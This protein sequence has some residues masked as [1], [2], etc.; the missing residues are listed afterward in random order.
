MSAPQRLNVLLSRARNGL[1]II[2]NA[3]TFQKSR[4]A[5]SVWKPFIQQLSDNGHLFDGFPTKCEQHPNI[6]AILANPKDFDIHCPSG[7]CSRDW[8]VWT[9]LN[10]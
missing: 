10:K 3:D 6:T 4:K 1:I 9:V 5:S 7:G 2:G 8:Y